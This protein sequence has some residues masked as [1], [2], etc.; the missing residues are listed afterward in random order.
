MANK[1]LTNVI[2]GLILIGLVILASLVSPTDIIEKSSNP[3]VAFAQGGGYH[4]YLPFL[5]RTK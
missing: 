5:Y 4:I 3:S 1:K 2:F